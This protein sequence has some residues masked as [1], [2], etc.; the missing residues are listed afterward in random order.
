MHSR[1]DQEYNR[2]IGHEINHR[3]EKSVVPLNSA[4]KAGEKIEINNL[5]T[6]PST[7]EASGGLGSSP[8]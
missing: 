7:L 1:K 8:W 6:F 5:E 2:S 4:C 3:I